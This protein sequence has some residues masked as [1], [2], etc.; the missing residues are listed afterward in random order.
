MI[1]RR[2]PDGSM[3]D[4]TPMPFNVRTTVHEYGGRCSLI[5]GDTVY[6]S[7]FADQRLYVQKLDSAP[8]PLT[9]EVPWRYADPIIDR[10]RGR[11]ICVREDHSQEGR[12]A[13]NTLVA[14]DL[15]DGAN[16]KVL[17]SGSDFY[18]TPRLSPDGARLAWLSWNHPNLPWD[19]TELWVAALEADG[20][21]G[22]A[23]LVAG[24][25]EESIFQ[26]EWSPDGMLYFVSDRSGWWNLYRRAGGQ[27]E[28]LHPDGSR[29]R[30]AAV[31]VWYVD[32]YLRISRPPGVHLY[33]PGPLAP[34]DD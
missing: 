4:V 32:V 11:L 13:E 29:V 9:P 14:I 18:S 19:G 10:R 22:Q 6:F 20:S 31:G 8:Q 23:E 34:G 15:N 7:N 3:Q 33:P 16:Q 5:D 27:V 24:G 25:P 21:L 17:V 12:E 26:P 28:A 1:V 2:M 30:H